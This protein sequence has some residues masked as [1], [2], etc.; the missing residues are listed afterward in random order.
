MVCTG[1]TGTIGS[2]RNGCTDAAIGTFRPDH[3]LAPY[4][5]TIV[6]NAPRRLFLNSA[7]YGTDRGRDTT[8][9]VDKHGVV[10]PGVMPSLGVARKFRATSEPVAPGGGRMP[11]C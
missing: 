8:P 11:S 6:R 4:W 3:L 10:S 7:T 5:F 1:Q 9:Q 2:Y